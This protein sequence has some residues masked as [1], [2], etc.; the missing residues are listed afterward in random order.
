M[1]NIK[2]IASVSTGGSKF[3]SLYEVNGELVWFNHGE[4]PGKK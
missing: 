2:K 4:Y 1:M 3:M